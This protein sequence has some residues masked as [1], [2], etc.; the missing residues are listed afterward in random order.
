MSKTKLCLGRLGNHRTNILTVFLLKLVVVVVV[1]LLFII[2]IIIIISINTIYCWG[3]K[4]EREGKGG[5]EREKGRKEG[6]CYLGE[7]LQVGGHTFLNKIREVE[8]LLLR[9]LHKSVYI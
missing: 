8:F 1:L 7:F 2:I 9:R 4:R 6:R 5:G 3:R